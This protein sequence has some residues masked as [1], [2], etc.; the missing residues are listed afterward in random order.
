[1]STLALQLEHTLDQL[2]AAKRA[3]LEAK[4]SLV[5]SQVAPNVMVPPPRISQDEWKALIFDLAGS[6]PDFPDDF[7][8]M[9]RETDREPIE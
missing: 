9:P 6:L 4:V 8:E 5:I 2:D 1:M 7:E 3:E